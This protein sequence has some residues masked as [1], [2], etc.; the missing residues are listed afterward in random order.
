MNYGN[1]VGLPGSAKCPFEVSGYE[2]K[3]RPVSMAVDFSP[4]SVSQG[5][6]AGGLQVG[7]MEG[8]RVREQRA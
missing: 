8:R 7:V 4:G 6:R 1:V 2:F 5:G 3:A